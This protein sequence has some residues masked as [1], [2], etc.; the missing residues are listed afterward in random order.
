MAVVLIMAHAPLASA[1]KAVA[2]HVYPERG[3]DI[4]ALDVPPQSTPEE[5]LAQAQQLMALHPGQEWLVL[6]DVFG[7]TPCNAALRLADPATVRVVAGVNV[8]MMWRALCYSDESLDA[9]VAR[10]VTGAG[11]GVMPL[12]AHKPM[13]QQRPD[14]SSAKDDDSHP[15]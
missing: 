8:P 14:R 11:Q 6:V 15:Q 5:A 12:A 2:T 7:A 13:A 4:E 1:L 3:P 10:A 9:L